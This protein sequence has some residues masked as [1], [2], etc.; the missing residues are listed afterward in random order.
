MIQE[1]G[2]NT[3]E[4]CSLKVPKYYITIS[5]L[6]YIYQVTKLLLIIKFQYVQCHLSVHY[7]TG[8]ASGSQEP[9]DC[10]KRI[11]I[12]AG[13]GGSNNCARET[14][15]RR[16]ESGGNEVLSYDSLFSK[17]LI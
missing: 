3:E 2:I 8:A 11:L 5:Q 1:Q 14:E 15:D 16:G 4:E 9:T 7:C 6:I 10:F 12:W 17:N 13:Q